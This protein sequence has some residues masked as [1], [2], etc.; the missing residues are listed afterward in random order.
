MH[1]NALDIL[2]QGNKDYPETTVSSQLDEIICLATKYNCFILLDLA[3]HQKQKQLLHDKQ[4]QKISPE[5]FP[6][7]IF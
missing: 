1:F 7:N 3:D 6:Q 4:P 5:V 2:L